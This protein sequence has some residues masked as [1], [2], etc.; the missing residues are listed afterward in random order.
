MYK[1]R[2]IDARFAKIKAIVGQMARPSAAPSDTERGL[3]DQ[4]VTHVW[5]A[6]GSGGAIDDVAHAWRALHCGTVRLHDFSG[7]YRNRWRVGDYPRHHG[8]QAHEQIRL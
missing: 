6:L 4:A 7:C 5:D 8:R 1:K 3:I 2:S